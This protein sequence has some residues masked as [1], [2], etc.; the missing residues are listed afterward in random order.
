MKI[1]TVGSMVEVKTRYSQG[2]RMI[3]PQPDY[4]VYEGK[5]L[6]SYKWLN[7]RQFCLSG[8][9][10]WPIR[11][12]NMDYVDDISILSGSFKE[13][14]TGTRIIEV[15][16]SK[17]SKYIVTSDSKGWTCTCTGFQ[18]RKQCKHISELSK[19]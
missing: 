12:I 4:N 2:P 3:P 18:F 16:G 6:P 15:A 19:A 7:D 11:V 17:G 1:P 8:N 14:D 9:T 5:V 13:V 10:A